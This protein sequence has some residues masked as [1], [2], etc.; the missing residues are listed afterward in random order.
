MQI[1]HMSAQFILFLHKCNKYSACVLCELYYCH[2]SLILDV[3]AIFYTL[4]KCILT[5]LL[6]LAMLWMFLGL[7][8]ELKALNCG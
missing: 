8:G 5:L 3:N 4:A 1:L 6:V 2:R 7:Q